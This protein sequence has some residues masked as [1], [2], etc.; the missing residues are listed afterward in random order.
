MLRS[1]FIGTRRCPKV[2]E[3]DLGLAS[4][5]K[6]PR[7]LMSSGLA[8]EKNIGNLSPYHSC[9][10]H[11]PVTLPKHV[12]QM[13]EAHYIYIYIDISSIFLKNPDP[14]RW[15][16]I[17]GLNPIS[18]KRLA[19]IIPSLGLGHDPRILFGFFCEIGFVNTKTSWWFQTFFFF[20]PLFG[21][22]FQFDSYLSEGVETTN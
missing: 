6:I 9:M 3:I 10:L 14:S 4:T 8:L 19:D 7:K 21:E 5:W 12:H 13:A 22:D 1:W 15:S 18:R 17:D 2:N 16:R 11:L 20:K